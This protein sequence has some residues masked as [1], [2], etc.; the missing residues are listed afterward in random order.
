MQQRATRSPNWARGIVI[1]IVATRERRRRHSH[2]VPTRN[3]LKPYGTARAPQYGRHHRAP[4]LLWAGGRPAACLIHR[5]PV[6]HGGSP[7]VVPRRSIP[8]PRTEAPSV[9]K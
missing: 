6:Q 3:V 5:L 2:S 7:R 1:D 8:S 4:L 9:H